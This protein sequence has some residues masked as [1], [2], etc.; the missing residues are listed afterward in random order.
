MKTLKLL[1]LIGF[2]ALLFTACEKDE[3]DVV[4]KWNVDKITSEVYSGS[5]ASGTPIFSYS[6]T[7]QGWAQFNSDG[8]GIADDQEP[9]TWTLSG[10]TLS[11]FP[12]GDESIILTLTTRTSTKMVGFQTET[13]TEDLTTFTEK[14]TI[15]FR[16]L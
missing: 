14:S 15:E 9:F 1:T 8:T 7:N 11:I 3:F 6:L 16:K 10:N 12:T 13:Y 4:G 5:S 2:F